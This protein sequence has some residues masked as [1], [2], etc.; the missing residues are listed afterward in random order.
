MSEKLQV[1]RDKLSQMCPDHDTVRQF[2]KLFALATTLISTGEFETLTVGIDPDLFT[3]D[4]TG[5]WVNEGE[6]T[7]WDEI[8]TSF[9]G[10]N[11]YE[12]AGRVDYNY[13]ELTLDF[14][15]NARYPNEPVGV[16]IQTPHARKEGS[17]IRPHIHWMQTSDAVPNILI[18]YRFCN[19]GEAPG[20]WTLKA[21]TEDDLLF[22]YT[23][24]GMM[25]IVNFN[26]PEDHG[27]DLGLSSTID[28][29][30]YR[31]SLNTSGL[32]S[33][34]DTYSGAWSAKYYDIH[35]ER[36]MN[37]SREEYTK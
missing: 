13:T 19:N 3:V 20:S 31:D 23:S 29:K 37:G 12:V 27:A 7:T 35:F 9:V 21:L 8:S 18:E 24:S 14:N 33:G 26:L 1:T 10:N 36:D 22:E 2:E 30:I 25:Q 34:V 6:S 11:I 17:D 5:T 32:F 28:V 4:E 16:V 15:T